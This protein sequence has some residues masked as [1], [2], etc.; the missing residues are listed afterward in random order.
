MAT[1]YK[2]DEIRSLRFVEFGLSVKVTCQIDR[3]VCVAP[4][5]RTFKY[6][7][8]VFATNNGIICFHMIKGKRLWNSLGGLAAVL[9]LQGCIT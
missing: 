8:Q 6:S 2:Q 3:D 9:L 5:A 7:F 4:T 1:N